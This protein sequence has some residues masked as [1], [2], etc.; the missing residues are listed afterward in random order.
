MSTI[1]T[2]CVGGARAGQDVAGDGELGP[3]QGRG[4]GSD[5]SEWL[6]WNRGFLPTCMYSRIRVLTGQPEQIGV[7]VLAG[8]G[9]GGWG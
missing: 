9:L 6:S 1:G 3:A 5:W 2:G 8:H 7:H 4:C